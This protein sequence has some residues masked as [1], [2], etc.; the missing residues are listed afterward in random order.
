MGVVYKAR[1]IRLNRLVALKMILS[2]NHAN[3]HDQAR[4]RAE[5]EAVAYLQHPN[6][7]QIYEIGERDGRPFFSLEYLDGGSL[8]QKIAKEPLPAREAARLVQALAEAMDCAHQRGIIHRDLKPANVLLTVDGMPKITDFGLAKRLQDQDQGHTRTGAVMGTPSYMSPEQAQGQTKHLGPAADI[9]SL[10]AILYDLITGR[11]PFRGETLLDTLLQ[12]KTIE[13]VPPARLQPQLARDLETI[14]LKC[15]QK[16]PAKRYATAGA[17]AEDLRRFL[18]GEPI[19]ARPIPTW[20]RA[21]KWARRRPAAAALIG[22]SLLAVA[23]VIGGVFAFGVQERRRAAEALHLQGLAD[24][25]RDKAEANFAKARA[26]VDQM[27]TRVAAERLAHQPRTEKVRRALLEEAL[28]FYEGFLRERATDPGLRW[29]VGR[30]AYRV[31]DIQALLGDT[32]KAEASYGQA[33]ATFTQLVAEFPNKPD[34]QEDLAAS[35]NNLG[36]L[37]Q[38]TGR[39]SQA[40]RTYHRAI[41]QYRGLTEQNSQDL[42]YRRLLAGGYHNLGTLQMHLGM[43][44]A[45]KNL[46][47]ALE[48]QQEL[49]K[50]PAAPASQRQELAHSYDSLG[51]WLESRGRTQEAVQ[52]YTQAR[53]LFGQLQA[54]DP[55]MPEYRQEL[56]ITQQHFGDLYRDTDPQ[57]AERA[58]QQALT[59]RRGL[60]DNYPKVPDYR[61]DVAN[62]NNALGTLQLAAGRRDQAEDAFKKA[63]E[64]KA[65]LAAQFPNVPDYRRDLANAWTNRALLLQT[66][67]RREAASAAYRRALALF[68]KLVA[69]YP[70]RPEYQQDRAHAQLSSCTLLPPADAD[71][72]CRQ[73]LE[74]R[75]GLAAQFA[76][77]VNFQLEL[78]RTHHVLGKLL[79]DQ[80]KWTDA[81]KSDLRAIDLLTK[82]AEKAPSV[83]YIRSILALTYNNLA[84]VYQQTQ[85]VAAL[86]HTWAKHQA[87]VAQLAAELPALPTYRE[88]FARGYAA[89]AA[90]LAQANKLDAAKDNMQKAARV[91]EGLAKDYPGRLEYLQNLANNYTDLATLE[92]ADGRFSQELKYRKQLVEFRRRLLAASP[93]EPNNE[94]ALAVAL[95]TL[96][97]RLLEHSR[98]S[99]ARR[100]LEEAIRLEQ[101]AWQHAPVPVYQQNLYAHY[102][103]LLEVLVQAEDHAGAA[104]AVAELGKVADAAWPE[105]HRAAGYLAR[106]AGL[107]VED[108]KLAELARK[109]LAQ[110]YEDQAFKRLQAALTTGYKEPA[111]RRR[112]LDYLKQDPAFQSLR[113]R[114]DF[115][116][117]LADEE[118]AVKG[119]PR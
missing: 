69:D 46:R 116:K 81:E 7:V 91:W 119:R 27:L 10:G 89:L 39:T 113:R 11:P 74:L 97:G 21:W 33:I 66:Q 50:E 9:Y 37:L 114:E 47:L 77:E 109:E 87:V 80:K 98:L 23:G 61:R 93:D 85:D 86:E 63:L 54:E 35:Y 1:Q 14:C 5:A 49:V 101:R 48:L 92:E 43:P 32:E 19:Q 105:W 34:Y 41:A 88:Q 79:Q 100:A 16:D 111:D 56:A 70:G 60:V 20:E 67:K 59:L 103:S 83:P 115:K 71:K 45:E 65:D 99:E 72:L 108:E 75:T 84:L 24:E 12:V 73:V 8:A 36:I 106:C 17:L 82:L 64:M 38:E 30:A 62:T 117:L 55:D 15:L 13:P 28:S 40:E 4:F 107:A 110:R 29:E 44:E 31:G 26:A 95:H 6:I 68:D 96:G 90:G 58:Y 94:A 78:A 25:Q 2:G 53:D 52:A 51:Q 22:V 18:A 118:V 57:R 76:D 42:K 112:A 3:Q 104:A 102:L